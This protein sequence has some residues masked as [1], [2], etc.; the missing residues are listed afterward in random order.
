MHFKDLLPIL[1]ELGVDLLTAVG[2]GVSTPTDAAGW[3]RVLTDANLLDQVQAGLALID[4][5]DFEKQADEAEAAQVAFENGRA[6]TTLTDAEQA[7]SMAFGNLAMRLRGM[8]T[9]KAMKVEPVAIIG[10][11]VVPAVE[12]AIPL[13]LKAVDVAL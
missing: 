1:R 3:I 11:Y 5:E 13:V 7:Q 12:T 6:F 8:A 4:G 2:T 9:A 10:K